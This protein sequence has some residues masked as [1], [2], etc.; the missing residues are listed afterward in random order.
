MQESLKRAFADINIQALCEQFRGAE[1]RKLVQCHLRKLGPRLELSILASVQAC[2]ALERT[3]GEAL[4]DEYNAMAMDQA[5]WRRDCGEVLQEICHRF[6]EEME[7]AGRAT[8]SAAKFNMFQLITLSLAISAREHR[9]LRTFAG[10]RK[11]WLFR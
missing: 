6:G 7:A 10:I 1:Y 5:F 11:S 8:D 4:I 3:V 9:N 2:D